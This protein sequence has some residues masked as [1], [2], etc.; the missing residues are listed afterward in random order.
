MISNR[1]P[2]G[3]NI[4]AIFYIFLV[5]VFN[6]ILLYLG[7]LKYYQM[8]IFDFRTYPNI[9]WIIFG[10]FQTST[11]YW[12]FH[13]F[14]YVE[15]LQQIQEQIWEHLLKIFSCLNISKQ[16]KFPTFWKL[17]DIKHLSTSFSFFQ[18]YGGSKTIVFSQG[19]HKKWN[20]TMVD[21]WYHFGILKILKHNKFGKSENLRT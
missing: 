12:P 11:K 6:C 20:L 3:L 7:G 16:A 18:Y 5:I 10:T 19:M 13:L 15:M 14:V 9:R 1:S 2:I 17:P 4:S 8:V 21:S